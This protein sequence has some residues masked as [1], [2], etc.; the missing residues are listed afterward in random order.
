MAKPPRSPK[1]H[2]SSA[3]M[4]WAIAIL[5]IAAVILGVSAFRN[6]L[7]GGVKP[8]RG[9]GISVTGR[10]NIYRLR[11]DHLPPPFAT[12]SAANPPIVG[13]RPADVHLRV[14][15]GFSV[16]AWA[17]GLDG[18]RTMSLAPNGD[19]FVAESG[20]GKITV[21]RSGSNGAVSKSV[22][23]Q[24]LNR[25]FGMAFYPMG[26]DPKWVYIANTNSVI[27]YP[28]KPGDLSASGRAEKVVPDLPAGGYNNHWTR[29]L[30]FSPDGKKLYISVGS[31]GNVDEEEPHRAAILECNPDGADLRVYASGLR[32]PVGLA[33]GPVDHR[34]WTAVNERDGLGD[35]LV[36]DFA[37]SVQPGGFYGWPYYYMGRNHDP[38]MPERPDLAAKTLVPDVPFEAHSAAVS[39]AFYRGKQFPH[40][41]Y[42]DAFV[43]M[44][45]S[46]NRAHR[47]GYKVVRLLM[48]TDGTATGEYEDFVWGWAVP[49]R[50]VWGRPVDVL[51]APDGAL[52]V[53]DDGS[54][55]IWRVSYARDYGRG[56]G[57]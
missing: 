19:V 53:S 3:R 44:H 46:W 37:T 6:G 2:R 12:H 22:F 51:V 9:V 43:G 24:G 7:V 23:A 8:E 4:R 29:R 26:S 35:D 16:A 47:T 21:L 54:G 57:E 5:L 1:L 56:A 52:L 39:I 36:P 28:Y 25:P 30:L 50:G 31:A 20:P 14:P 49:G 17:I 11:L 13:S 34:L 48:R 55:T 38:R 32:N 40:S 41:Y 27:R 45:G 18:P 42:N 15:K 10:P 33:W